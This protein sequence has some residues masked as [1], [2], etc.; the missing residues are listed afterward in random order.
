MDTS[1][2][3]ATNLCTTVNEGF[4][5]FGKDGKYQKDSGEG[6]TTAVDVSSDL[7]KFVETFNTA[8]ADKAPSLLQWSSKSLTELDKAGKSITINAPWLTI[9]KADEQ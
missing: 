7:N 1:M 5:H 3:P 4:A 9:P 6:T 2:T 8:N